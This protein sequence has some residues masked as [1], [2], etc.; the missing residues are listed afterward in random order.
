MKVLFVIHTL[1][2]SRGIERS[3]VELASSLAG[4]GVTCRVAVLEDVKPNLDPRLRD[5]G[6][7]L[8]Q[9]PG[10]RQLDRVRALRRLARAECP[11]IVHTMT[12]PGNVVGAFAMFGLRPPVLASVV[13]AERGTAGR[14]RR[15]VAHTPRGRALEWVANRFLIDRFHAVSNAEKHA[16]A[17]GSGVRGDRVIVAERGRDAERLGEPGPE[18]RRKV[19]AALGVPLNAPLILTVGVEDIRK[20]HATA[21]AALECIA[22]TC[23]DAVL[24]LAGSRGSASARL[25]ALQEQSRFGT[26]IRRLGHRDDVPDLL[27]AADVFVFPSRWEGLP[28][29]VI[30]AM[31]MALPVVAADTAPNRELVDPEV[32]GLLFPVGDAH[33]CA[34]QIERVLSNT[35]LAARWGVEG[36][37]H[38]LARHLSEHATHRM[39]DLYE[40]VLRR[41]R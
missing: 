28:G 37:R 9:V 34:R 32:T 10:A 2:R 14:G 24:L 16:A 18:R 6:V 8:T 27:A 19:R 12:L 40:V 11:D 25:D 30:E 21:V 4:R 20:D 13:V 23:S 41:H 22:E 31:A 29:A 7:P 38:Y 3:L 1:V 15:A 17:G 5:S 39:L 26:Q 35:A 33:A 36:R